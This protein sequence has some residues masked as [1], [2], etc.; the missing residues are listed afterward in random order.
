MRPRIKGNNESMSF[1]IQELD[2]S[3]ASYSTIPNLTANKGEHSKLTA[4][5]HA[6]SGS[7]GSNV[8]I[9]AQFDK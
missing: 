7:T 1:E 2:Q 6:S 3:A 4:G 8:K 5:H 9:N